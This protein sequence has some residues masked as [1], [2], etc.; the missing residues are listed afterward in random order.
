M[1]TETMS[2]WTALLILSILVLIA[3]PIIIGILAAIVAGAGWVFW[4]IF[5]ITVKLTLFLLG[6]ALA[7]GFLY[8][9]GYSG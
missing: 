5:T 7:T 8:L 9:I 3:I 1:E 2:M 4:A 6:I